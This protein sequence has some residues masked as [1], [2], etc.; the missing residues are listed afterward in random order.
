[1]SCTVHQ[2]RVALP[3][4]TNKNKNA[5]LT[6]KR[7]KK[8]KEKKHCKDDLIQTYQDLPI[9]LP[10]HSPAGKNL[11]EMTAEDS[12]IWSNFS[13]IF[14]AEPEGNMYARS[15]YACVAVQAKWYQEQAPACLRVV[16][17]LLNGL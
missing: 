5:K 10:I 11:T 13:S 8:K 14:T 9:F 12:W 4:K 7:K 16:E 1:M 15:M 17:M 3:L 6:K 2:K